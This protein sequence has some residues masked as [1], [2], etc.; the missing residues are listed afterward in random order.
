MAINYVVD[1][2]LRL[3]S[4]VSK[5]V[6]GAKGDKDIQQV[7]F[8]VNRFYNGFDFN[9]RFNFRV[10]VMLPNEELATVDIWLDDIQLLDG[11]FY[12]TWTISSAMTKEPGPITFALEIYSEITEQN[13][14]TT[15]TT[16]YIVDS[17]LLPDD[18]EIQVIEEPLVPMQ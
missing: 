7:V 16:G 10:H 9:N 4:T 15:K 6:L 8:E 14:F 2:D 1:S 12:I 11:V 13:F 18:A 3:N 17:I 5:A